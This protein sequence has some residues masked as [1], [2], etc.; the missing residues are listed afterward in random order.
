MELTRSEKSIEFFWPDWV[1]RHWAYLL[2]L[3][4]WQQLFSAF[5]AEQIDFNATVI[6]HHLLMFVSLSMEVV[7]FICVTHLNVCSLECCSL[8][9]F[10][11]WHSGKKQ[12]CFHHFCYT[13]NV[14]EH[15]MT[16]SR[17]IHQFIVLV[18]WA[19]SLKLLKRCWGLLKNIIRIIK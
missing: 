13:I 4:W 11:W 17:K 7:T 15:S 10:S 3:F 8:D 12:Y 16:W 2:Y 9:S 5:T 19:K 1:Q 18:R 6:F 14:S